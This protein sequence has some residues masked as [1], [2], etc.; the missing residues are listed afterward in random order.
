MSFTL[1]HDTT[2]QS[3]ADWGLTDGVLSERS[4]SAGTF[5]AKVAGDALAAL[6]WAYKDKIT[7]RDASNVVR[8]VGY[9][10]PPVRHGGDEE[11]IELTF[12]NAWWFLGRSVYLQ[13]A[14][15]AEEADAIQAGNVALFAAVTAGTGWTTRSI[16]AEVAAIIGQ[17]AAVFSGT[18][19]LGDVTGAAFAKSP[20]PQRVEG[21]T[22]EQ[23]LRDALAYVPDAV[24]YWDYTTTPPTLHF[25]QRSAGTAREL[26]MA[27]LDHEPVLTAD[28]ERAAR[29]VRLLYKYNTSDGGTGAVIDEAGE[30]TGDG[31][32]SAVVDLTGGGKGSGAAPPVFTPAVKQIFTVESEAIDPLSA[33]WWF[34]YGDTGVADAGD[35]IVGAASNIAADDGAGALGTK[36]RLFVTGN[37]PAEL[38]AEHLRQAVVT[39]YLTVSTTR[40]EAGF[41]LTTNEQRV[42]QVR[43]T[44]T[45]Y[46]GDEEYS[47]KAG[48]FTGGSDPDTWTALTIPGGI[49]A[50]LLAVWSEVQHRGKVS[51]TGD[52]CGFAVVLG[53]VINLTGGLEAW[54]DMNAQVQGIEHEL[55]YGRT[56]YTLGAAEHLRIE[57]F[58]SML[59]GLKVMLA[60]DLDTQ[61]TGQPTGDSTPTEHP[62]MVGKYTS[63]RASTVAFGY[64]WEYLDITRGVKVEFDGDNATMTHSREDGSAQ[65]EI[66]PDA[67]KSSNPITEEIAEV[68]PVKMSVENADGDVAEMTAGQLRL[69]DETGAVLTL[70]PDGLTLEKDGKT[71]T[72]SLLSLLHDDGA[73]KT[74]SVT[75]DQVIG[76]DG[77][78][79][80]VMDSAEGFRHTV[81]DDEATLTK[82]A[83]NIEGSGGAV[84]VRP[85]AGLTVTTGGDAA[86]VNAARLRIEGA[87]TTEVGTVAGETVTLTATDFCEPDGTESA[88]VLR[89]A[90]S[91]D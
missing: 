26:A 31:I 8:F 60:L 53:D 34:K 55:D 90:L 33:A 75:E 67:V 59:Q 19:Q 1:Q 37:I 28:E 23:A 61:A 5:T 10:L 38:A 71:T 47:V 91:T 73:G 69:E 12:A 40:E 13:E 2:T 85:E 22:Y 63:P 57:D 83:L 72:L 11:I 82:T 54:E 87:G 18:M 78:G 77:T 3:L 17:C 20:V 86:N 35:I 43:C 88:P 46:N 81:G 25:R 74:M 32:I 49:A 24:Q 30:G 7:L 80:V 52:E 29:G 84:E 16:A 4:L 62:A 21:V 50:E 56:I 6:P 89:G 68:S 15:N 27:A 79:T 66:T 64:K 70:T 9:A 76:D 58:V 42:V 36:N 41:T 14:W 45:D 44:T 65:V 39:G 51:V 48:G